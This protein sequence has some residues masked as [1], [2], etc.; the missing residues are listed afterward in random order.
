MMKNKACALL[1]PIVFAS[2]AIAARA[3]RLSREYYRTRSSNAQSTFAGAQ[4]PRATSGRT[5]SFPAQSPSTTEGWIQTSSL[6]EAL[7]TEAAAV[8]NGF[9]YVVGGLSKGTPTSKVLYAKINSDGA[10]GPF[11]ETTPLPYTLSRYLCGVVNNNFIYAIGGVA[12]GYTTASVMYAP[13]QS[14][15]TVGEWTYTT[16]LPEPLQLQGTLANR[17]Y[18]YVLGG[19]TAPTAEPGDETAAVVYAKFNPDGTLGPFTSTTELPAEDYKTCPV[20]DRGLIY[21]LGGET[22]KA[23]SAVWYASPNR[24]GSVSGWSTATPLPY[25][26]AATAVVN[27][28]GAI[29]MMGGDTTGTGGDTSGVV[30]GKTVGLGT[31]KWSLLAPLPEVT[32]RQAGAAYNGY[33]YSIGGLSP[34]IDTSAVY[35]M[36]VSEK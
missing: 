18:L 36:S 17:G 2:I 4:T 1:I 28:N 16:S 26:N 20:A 7:E 10:L 13:I 24:D 34:D 11:Q 14:D 8:N 3:A 12:N 33:V 5:A 31:I 23:T 32:S 19:S 25:T 30:S 6:P 29:V 22:P 21:L 9:L 27:S 15:G 35:Y